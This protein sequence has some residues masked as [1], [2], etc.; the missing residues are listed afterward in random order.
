[1]V[2]RPDAL[3]SPGAPGLSK[4]HRSQLAW[5]L[6]GAVTKLRLTSDQ[7]REVVA[8]Y[9]RAVADGADA[10]ETLSRIAAEVDRQPATV[11]N[12]IKDGTGA[13]ARVRRCLRWKPKTFLG[14]LVLTELIAAALIS[15]LFIGISEYREGQREERAKQVEDQRQLRA[16]QLENLRFVRTALGRNRPGGG[17]SSQVST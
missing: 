12:W 14:E 16:E 5:I 13:R 2:L 3:R 11:A 17:D 10:H 8:R 9:E 4:G 1:M 6:F 7:R 15:A